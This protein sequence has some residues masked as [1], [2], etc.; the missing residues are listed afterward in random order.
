M[1]TPDRYRPDPPKVFCSNYSGI[2]LN[3]TYPAE[4]SRGATKRY[5]SPQVQALNRILLMGLNWFRRGEIGQSEDRQTADD[6]KSTTIIANDEVFAL[7][8]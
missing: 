4:R 3:L 2:T 1:R 5:G 7:A 6:K 8:A